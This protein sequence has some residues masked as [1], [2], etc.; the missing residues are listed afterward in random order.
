MPTKLRLVII[1]VVVVAAAVVC[2]AVIIKHVK[3]VAARQYAVSQHLYVASQLP[4][5][6]A[7]DVVA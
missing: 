1:I 6:I 7:A 3:I 2:S 5:K 4:S